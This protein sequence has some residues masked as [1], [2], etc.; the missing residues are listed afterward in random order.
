MYRKVASIIYAPPA[1]PCKQGNMRTSAGYS[2]RYSDELSS[3][4]GITDTTYYM[5]KWWISSEAKKTSRHIE[6]VG[7]GTPYYCTTMEHDNAKWRTSQFLM[8]RTELLSGR[9]TNGRLRS[10]SDQ[11]KTLAPT[12]VTS[13]SVTCPHTPRDSCYRCF[14]QYDRDVEFP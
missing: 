2:S 1:L 12:S 4:A 3:E 13:G 11:P 10:Q 9:I 8:V 5:Y 14:P 6:R 7:L